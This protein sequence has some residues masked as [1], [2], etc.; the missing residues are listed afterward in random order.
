MPGSARACKQGR[1]DGVSSIGSGYSPSDAGKTP[2]KGRIDGS[3]EAMALETS[4]SIPEP[5]VC[6]PLSSPGSSVW[7]QSVLLITQRRPRHRYS[8][9]HPATS[10][11]C[12]SQGFPEAPDLAILPCVRNMFGLVE[13]RFGSHPA[14]CAPV[15]LRLSLAAP[16]HS[17]PGTP[18]PRRPHSRSSRPRPGRFPAA[19]EVCGKLREAANRNSGD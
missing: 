19:C 16:P 18:E 9:D 5:C 15:L 1:N 12:A 7:V 4:R 3:G 13:H 10:C 8:Y 11:P 6:I 17:L 14:F 2:P